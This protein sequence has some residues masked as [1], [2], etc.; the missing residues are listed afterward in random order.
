MKLELCCSE[1]KNETTEI[2]MYLKYQE[3]F[4]S[5]SV[6]GNL[7]SYSVLEKFTN[8]HKGGS[9]TLWQS[10]ICYNIQNDIELKI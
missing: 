8:I 9:V 6:F 10:I 4:N 3:N 7:A 1:F 5:L 2:E